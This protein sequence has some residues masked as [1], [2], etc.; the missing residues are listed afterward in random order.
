MYICSIG[1][2]RLICVLPISSATTYL[3]RCHKDI[4]QHLGITQVND[5]NKDMEPVEAL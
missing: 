5:R 1:D 4:Q 3:L 2:L